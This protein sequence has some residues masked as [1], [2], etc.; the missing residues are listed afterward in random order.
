[1]YQNLN[2]QQMRNEDGPNLRSV[3]NQIDSKL[4]TLDIFL[5]FV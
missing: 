4:L 3:L 2:F 1:M 5:T